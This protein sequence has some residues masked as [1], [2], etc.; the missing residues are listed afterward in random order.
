MFRI[1][2]VMTL[3]AVILPLVYIYSKEGRLDGI[4][5]TLIIG[6]VIGGIILSVAIYYHSFQ[7]EEHMSLYPGEEVILQR[8]YP[9]KSLVIP[10]DIDAINKMKESPIE[11]NLYLTN[12]GVMAEPPGTGEPILHI[13]INSIQ[14]MQTINRVLIKYIRVRYIDIDNRVSEVLL[15]LGEDTDRWAER[16]GK[17]MLKRI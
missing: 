12:L 16:I 3:L 15:Y 10:Q 2:V 9:N 1:G 7:K 14:E 4:K 8:K 11:V 6:G 13:A 5:A 17:M